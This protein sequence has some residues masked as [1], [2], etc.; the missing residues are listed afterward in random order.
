MIRVGGKPRHEEPEVDGLIGVQERGGAGI[1]ILA[2]SVAYMTERVAYN[3][4]RD[5]KV[6]HTIYLSDGRKVM[7]SGRFILRIGM[8]SRDAD[9]TVRWANEELGS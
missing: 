8:I 9:G 2:D 1:S 6:V 3:G 4:I 7:L 5:S